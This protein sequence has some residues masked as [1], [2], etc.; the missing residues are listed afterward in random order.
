M[1]LNKKTIN[2]LNVTLV[3]ISTLLILNLFN[4]GIPNIGFAIQDTFDPEEPNCFASYQDNVEQISLNYCCH[5]SRKQLECINNKQTINTI[6]T[7]ITCQTGEN[8]NTIKY[9]LTNKAYHSCLNS[10]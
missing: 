7:D 5:E 4:I 1:N 6:E 2:I 9:H 10:Y 8:S 3:I